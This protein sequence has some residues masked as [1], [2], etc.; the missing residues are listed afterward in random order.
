LTSYKTLGEVPETPDLAIITIP[1][2]GIIDLMKEIGV[3][4]VKNVVVLAAGFKE[5][6]TAGVQLEKDLIELA[7]KYEINLLGPN[8]LGFVNNLCPINATFGEIVR[9]QN[10]DLLCNPSLVTVFLI[11]ISI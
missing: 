9:N 2:L 7:K 8:C 5:T 1:A 10:L 4:G 11:G 3:K 6:G